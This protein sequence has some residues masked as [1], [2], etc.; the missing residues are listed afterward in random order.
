MAPDDGTIAWRVLYDEAR[1]RL[2]TGVD[3]PDLEAR[4]IVEAASG[5]EGAAFA[6]GLAELV[7]EKGIVRFDTMIE[8]RLGGEPLQYVIGRWGFRTL[9]LAVDRRVLIPRPETETVVE[10][11]LCELDRVSGRRVLDLGTGSGAIALSMA[12]ERADIEVWA[13]E[14][15]ADAAAV[16]RANLTGIGQA[17]TRVRLLEGSWFDPLESGLRGRFDLI[18]SNPPYVAASDPLPAVVADWEPTEAL[19]PGPAGTE[20]IEHIITTAPQWLAPTG[21]MVI[22]LAP[23]QAGWAVDAA[24]AAGFAAAEISQDLAGRDRMLVARR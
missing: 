2:S 17:A 1:S 5:H 7:T 20:A 19:I 22:E 4:R 13:V 24:L 6:L 21:V 15:S 3:R 23:H 10:V 12:V 18:V 9:D 11:A 14:R 8:R 16:A